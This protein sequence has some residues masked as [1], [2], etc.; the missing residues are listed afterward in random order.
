MLKKCQILN[1]HTHTFPHTKPTKDRKMAS[2]QN[3]YRF[4]FL[5]INWLKSIK[6]ISFETSVR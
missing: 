6:R 4:N 5:F 1:I 3:V 2:Y